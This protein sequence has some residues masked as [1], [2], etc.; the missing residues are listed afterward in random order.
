MLNIIANNKIITHAVAASDK[1]SLEEAFEKIRRHPSLILP[2]SETLELAQELWS[3][4]VGRF[5]IENR[6]LNGYWT[7]NL[8]LQI[9][10]SF[11]QHPLENWIRQKAPIVKATR[12]RF[13]FFILE[14]EKRLKE[15]IT[16]ASIPCG[17]M[18]GIFEAQKRKGMDISKVGIDL[19]EEVMEVTRQNSQSIIPTNKLNFIKRDAWDLD[20]NDQYDILISNGLNIY[21]RDHDKVKHLYSNFYKAMKKGGVMITSF[22][23]P[24]PPHMDCVFCNYDKSD[25]RFQEVIFNNIFDVKWKAFMSEAEM[26]DLLEDIGFEVIDVIYDSQRMFPTITAKKP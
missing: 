12:E 1:V 4:P 10:D 19:D 25:L 2:L 21:E 14:L 16:L 20:I 11:D 5:L 24:P 22:L 8:I 9:Q 3:I 15:G 17:L 18:S 13:R 6:G 26:R 7:S 23:T